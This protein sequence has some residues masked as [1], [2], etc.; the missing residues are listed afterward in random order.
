MELIPNALAVPAPSSLAISAADARA[1]IMAV[2]SDYKIAGFDEPGDL[3][4]CAAQGRKW[5]SPVGIHYR[6]SGHSSNLMGPTFAAVASIIGTICII[7]KLGVT[8]MLLWGGVSAIAGHLG[9]DLDAEPNQLNLRKRFDADPSAASNILEESLLELL[10]AG[11]RAG[12]RAAVSQLESGATGAQ[13]SETLSSGLSAVVPGFS[14]ASWMFKA[15]SA[16]LGVGRDDEP[17]Y[18]LSDKDKRDFAVAIKVPYEIVDTV[19]TRAEN[20]LTS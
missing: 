9:V 16:L 8:G 12:V 10:P 7:R 4:L 1:V 5:L 15:L 19:V 20:E 6:F 13:V 17:S 18:V 14:V 11:V 3:L 2:G